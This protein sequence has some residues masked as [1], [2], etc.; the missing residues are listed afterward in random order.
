MTKL[1]EDVR[2]TLCRIEL[3]AR[4]ISSFEIEIFFLVNDARFI[5]VIG[6]RNAYRAN[7]EWI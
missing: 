3:N 4:V 2:E 6:F 1:Y 5:A 7:D